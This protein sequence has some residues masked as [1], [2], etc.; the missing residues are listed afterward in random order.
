MIN[1]RENGFF[2]VGLCERSLGTELCT[3]FTLADYQSEIRRVLN[4]SAVPLPPAKY[5]G[6][7]AVEFNG[8]VDYQLL[9]VGGDGGVYSAPLSGEYSFSVPYDRGE[10]EAG[11]VSVLCTVV[12]ESVSARVSAPRRLSIRCRLRPTVRIY[13][14]RMAETAIMSEVDPTS[15]YT[16][17]LSCDSLV[18]DSGVSDTITLNTSVSLSGDDVRVVSADTK[19]I[20]DNSEY[21]QDGMMCR[22]RVMLK[23]LCVCESNGEYSV[24]TKE[25]PFDGG[26][27]VSLGTPD[28]LCRVRGVLSEMSVNVNDAT[29]ECSMGILLEAVAEKNDE[30]VYTSDIY[31]TKNECEC[32]VADI[33]TRRVIAC[34][35]ANLT[36]SERVSLSS[37]GIP[38]DAVLIDTIGTVCFEKCETV[39]TK[40]VFGGNA[41]FTVIYKK[42]GEV[43]AS[44]V[45]LPVRY[46]MQ[47]GD[48]AVSFECTC[49][50]T[51][52][53]A[54]I[55]QGELRIDAELIMSADCMG[56]SRAEMIDN[57]RFGE[58]VQR[59]DSE[60]IVCYP[61]AED[62]LWSVAKRYKVA[63]EAILGDPVEDKYVVIE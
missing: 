16:Q 32:R 51:D 57:A 6:A 39:D 5:V 4:V 37:V 47:T 46:E 11:N 27:E 43:Y 42:D 56:E 38:E 59:A 12:S 15:V 28:G 17:D 48:T 52:I 7:D 31:S 22:G 19:I 29:A 20:I 35:N 10:C 8:I 60:L 1:E 41:D 50:A 53:R 24:L 63:P 34:Q 3:D 14:K 62:T 23:L 36:F 30:V 9:Y 49:E 18:C 21:S 25:I 26:L 45:K 40:Q 2:T 54:K 33:S 61:S 13:G 44:A 58:T 55:D